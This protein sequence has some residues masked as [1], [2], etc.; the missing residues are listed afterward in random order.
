MATWLSVCLCVCHVHV[1][2][3]NDWL[4]RSSCDFHDTCS[5][6]ILHG[7]L[8]KSKPRTILDRNVEN[9]AHWI[10]NTYLKEPPNFVRTYSLTLK[11]LIVKYRRQN[12]SV[13]V[14]L[15]SAGHWFWSDLR[16][17]ETLL[18]IKRVKTVQLLTRK[19]PDFIV[20]TL[21]PAYSPDL[22]L[23]LPDLGEA[24]GAKV[25]NRIHDVT[26]LKSRGIISTTW[27]T[28]HR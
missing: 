22:S 10:L 4:S 12:I 24:A 6:A 1:L 9:Y 27:S 18:S 3:P 25:R 19:T 28:D 2:C 11:L 21:C 16:W 5:P 20:P 7:V 15:I 13:F 14:S 23:P 17:Q 8:E 26:Q